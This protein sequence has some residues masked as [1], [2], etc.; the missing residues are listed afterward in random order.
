[1]FL[2]S[3]LLLLS[4]QD[5]TKEAYPLSPSFARQT[6]SDDTE[7]WS[8][9]RLGSNLPFDKDDKERCKEEGNNIKPPD[10]VAVDYFSNGKRLN[11]TLWFTSE[12]NRPA[13][14][15]VTDY[16]ILVDVNSVYDTGQDYLLKI[17]WNKLNQSWTRTL[18][19]ISPST[20]KNR[21]IDFGEFRVLEND[22]HPNNSAGFFEKGKNFVELDMSLDSISAPDQYSLV[23]LS[24]SSFNTDIGYFCQAV[25]ISDRVYVPPP[26]IL[27]SLSPSSVE[28]RPD[29]EKTIELQI[30]SS[31]NLDSRVVLQ[32]E[33]TNAEVRIIPEEIIVPSSGIAISHVYIQAPK[34]AQPMLSTI[35]IL[36]N[37]T[38]PTA[39]TNQLSGQTVNNSPSA[40]IYRYSNLTLQILEPVTITEQLNNIWKD[41][42]VPVSG[43][44]SLATALVAGLSSL[45]WF[46][47]RKRKRRKNSWQSY[48]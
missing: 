23:F 46:T 37:V 15:V 30:K 27:I 29:G 19:D 25:D 24:S 44:V 4:L 38:F 5:A 9:M 1:M 36:A 33:K 39:L 47:I 22:Q 28:L 35:P 48:D 7:D 13:P 10:L 31:T 8:F 21:I 32:P 11:S 17:G 16:Q 3:F 20:G 14:T 34:N 6:I 41:L 42:G 2:L 26:D 45:A 12:I 40:E 43:F 18:Q